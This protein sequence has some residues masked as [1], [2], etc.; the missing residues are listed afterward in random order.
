MRPNVRPVA[1][2]RSVAAVLVIASLATGFAPGSAAPQSEDSAQDAPEKRD[3]PATKKEAKAESDKNA[4][5][6]PSPPGAKERVA[7]REGMVERQIAAPADRRTKVRTPAVLDAVRTAPRHAFVPADVR[8]LAYRDSP[9]PIGHGQTISQPYMVAYMTDVLALDASS[10]VL[11]I[12]TGSGYQAAV[13]A[14]LT[15][16]VYTIEIIEPLH[17]NARKALEQEG[18]EN[19][20]CRFADGYNGWKEKGPFDAI[21]VTC[22]AGHIP[23][24]LWEQLAPG[25]RMVIPIGGPYEVQRL[26]LATKTEDGKRRTRTLTSVRFVPLTRG[27]E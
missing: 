3:E 26:V 11:E 16:H 10:K 4:W 24:P 17:E 2:R 18:Y 19:V 8:A 15:P 12:G 9:L 20:E 27:A 13:L 14:H 21:I 6:A 23:P 5:K 22:A 7:E 1:G 25:G